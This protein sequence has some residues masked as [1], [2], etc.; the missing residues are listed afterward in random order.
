VDVLVVVAIAIASGA[1]ASARSSSQS[2]SG[3]ASQCTPCRE[4]PAPPL[5]RTGRRRTLPSPRRRR[6]PS[7]RSRPP[8]C[9]Q[10]SDIAPPPSTS[11]VLVSLPT[12]PTPL[13]IGVSPAGRQLLDGKQRRERAVEESGGKGRFSIH[14]EMLKS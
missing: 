10:G 9:H 3:D 1:W 2:S 11:P 7:P 14:I 13:F 12:R 6:A 5:A 4:R 8:G